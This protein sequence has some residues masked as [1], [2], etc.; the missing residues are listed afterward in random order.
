MKREIK[1]VSMLF[2]CIVFALSV[3]SG[4]TTL[5]PSEA[6]ASQ[7]AE[8]NTAKLES[9]G[10]ALGY[11]VSLD[12]NPSI[13]MTIANGVVSEISAYN[14]DGQAIM[15]ESEVVGLEANAA[16]E[17]LVKA[18]LGAG[19]LDS[20]DVQPC[21]IIAVAENEETAEKTAGSLEESA[22]GVL[23]GLGVDC[24]VKGA[25]VSDD[26]AAEAAS[27]ELSVGRYMLLDYIAKAENISMQEARE[28]YSGLKMG[29]LM[30]MFEGLEDL[31]DE[32]EEE[33]EEP[34]TGL[35]PEQIAALEPALQAF[36]IELDAAQ[37]VFHTAFKAIKEEYKGKVE[38]L[39]EQFGGNAKTSEYKAALKELKTTM[40]GDRRAAIAARQDAFNIAKE[41]F[42]QAVAALGLPEALLESYID[43]LCEEKDVNEGFEEL[44]E[45]FCTEEDTEEP[46]QTKEQE[47]QAKSQKEMQNSAGKENKA[48]KENG[49]K[50]EQNNGKQKG[51][52]E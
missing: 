26:V 2:C 43:A 38:A 41:N 14:D 30:L 48:T 8:S 44:L 16:V 22:K 25:S 32:P 52:A 46:K 11:T 20:T 7:A 27:Y 24:I 5:I 15:L 28:K 29:E 47:Q 40:L 50:N 13:E 45:C 34:Q 37:D 12:V 17:E 9:A 21:L 51:K 35:T 42:R 19:Y 3:F 23:E 1:R 33:E 6:A 31:F 4:C 10:E 36:Q 49:N 18:L 39:K